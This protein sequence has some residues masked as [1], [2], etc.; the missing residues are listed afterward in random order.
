MSLFSLLFG[1]N[2]RQLGPSDAELDWQFRQNLARERELREQAARVAESEDY[3]QR[4]RDA[5]LDRNYRNLQ[6]DGW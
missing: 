3:A 6:N 5:E 4:Q 2:N 1:S